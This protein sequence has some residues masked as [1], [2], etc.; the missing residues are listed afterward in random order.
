MKPVSV[1]A[2]IRDLQQAD[3]TLTSGNGGSCS[4][5]FYAF[6]SKSTGALTTNITDQLNSL[7][8][9]LYEGWTIK[10]GVRPPPS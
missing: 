5:L 9:L 4:L 2:D 8:N 1:D 7:A 3:I 10:G 6:T